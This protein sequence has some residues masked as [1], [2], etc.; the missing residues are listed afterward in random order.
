M[1]YEVITRSSHAI[2]LAARPLLDEVARPFGARVKVVEIPP[3][4]PVWSPI[5]AEVYG[6]TQALREQAAAE[7]E[8]LFRQTPSYNFV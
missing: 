5:L 3:G 6:P 2:A 4:P 8:Q 7:L 1:L